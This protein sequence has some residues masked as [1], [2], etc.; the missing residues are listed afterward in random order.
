MIWSGISG[1]RRPGRCFDFV[2]NF[3]ADG[4]D[5]RKQFFK[6][7]TDT[8]SKFCHLVGGG[9]NCRKNRAQFDVVRSS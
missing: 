8:G 5:L 3:N 6:V 4:L 9:Q 1:S 7:G 2:G